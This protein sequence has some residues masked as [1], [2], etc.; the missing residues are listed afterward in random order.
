MDFLKS[1]FEF[2]SD[3]FKLL[4]IILLIF[5][6][7]ISIIVL[8]NKILCRSAITYCKMHQE[9]VAEFSN[10]MLSREDVDGDQLS[11]FKEDAD[12]EKLWRFK[13]KYCDPETQSVQYQGHT[14]G[15]VPSGTESGF[16]YTKLPEEEAYRA[17]GH[18]SGHSI[19]DFQITKKNNGFTEYFSLIDKNCLDLKHI[20]G[21]T[22]YYEWMW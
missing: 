3:I 14:Y 10:E 6:I 22:Y 18:Y 20:V 21:D 12:G 5:A 13:V 2:F 1:L 8:G 17:Y 15:I 16:L 7:I 4:S 19:E 11:R 9:T